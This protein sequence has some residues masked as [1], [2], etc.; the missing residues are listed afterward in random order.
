MAS[1]LQ[2][3]TQILSRFQQDFD[4]LFRPFSEPPSGFSSDDNSVI[5][6]EWIPP[7]N[8]HEAGSQF[9]ISINTPRMDAKDVELSIENGILSI[10]AERKL[11]R[12]EYRNRSLAGY[13][14][15]D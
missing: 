11:H 9:F 3:P 5:T 1:D 7:V 13:C 14:T 15:I 8:I 10:K 6:G 2:Q 12:S 4:D